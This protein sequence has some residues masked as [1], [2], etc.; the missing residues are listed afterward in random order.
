MQSIAS[1]ESKPFRS[2]WWV[3]LLRMLIAALIITAMAGP[4]WR[5]NG[6]STD[7]SNKTLI[8]VDDGWA[9]ASDWDLRI[10]K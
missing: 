8:I 1:V 3:L 2:P 7:Y 10:K 5:P 4:Q 9:A 6:A